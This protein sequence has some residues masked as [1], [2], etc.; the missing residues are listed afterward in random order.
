MNYNKKIYEKYGIK[1]TDEAMVTYTDREA[2]QA[3]ERLHYAVKKRDSITP[4]LM[5]DLETHVARYPDIPSFKNYLY[6]G[7]VFTNQHEKAINFLYKTIEQHPNYVFAHINLASQFVDKDNFTKAASILKEPYDVRNIDKGEFIHHSSFHSYYTTAFRIEL[8]RNNV[9]EAERLHRILFEYDAKDKDM[10]QFGLLLL[11]ARFKFGASLKAEKNR[12][13][14]S[15]S[16]PIKGDFMSDS[17]G[18]PV[19]NHFEIHQLY[20]YGLDN[21]PKKVIEQIL[22]LPRPTLIQDLEHVF[23]D[24]VLRYDYFKKTNWND[25]NNLFFIH[26]LY[27]LT[28]L[29]AYESLDTV[30]D[31]LR[32]DEDFTKFWLSDWMEEYFHPT[33]YLLGHNQ[34]DVLKN[35]VLEENVSSWHRLLACEVAAQVAMKRPERRGEI[36]KWFR[37]IMQYHLENAQNNNLIDSKFLSSL[38]VDVMHFGGVE[39]E[40]DIRMLFGKGWINPRVGGN[41]ETVLEDLYMNLNPLYNLPLPFGIHELYSG[42]FK[43]RKNKSNRSI[44][45]KLL[46]KLTDPHHNFMLSLMTEVMTKNASGNKNLVDDDDEDDDY[47]Y[48]L[49]PQMPIKRVESKVGRNDPC[50]CGSGKKYKKCHGN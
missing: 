16:K 2:L 33:L 43:E 21:M 37:D 12:E 4:A 24:T 41:L 18:Q 44:D 10:K 22:E 14:E 13:V 29:K 36:I 47:D 23:L 25:D 30:L 3:S 39:L 17:K 34:L 9:D 6:S 31:F 28:E 15:V 46:E 38:I 11:A 50:P 19:F 27:F 26:A 7:Y 45:P 20:A 1:V 35:F 42:A 8:G 40:E 48:E 49:A 5:A 32:Q